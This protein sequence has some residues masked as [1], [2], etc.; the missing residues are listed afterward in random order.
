MAKAVLGVDV[1]AVTPGTAVADGR[2]MCSGLAHPFTIGIVKYTCTAHIEQVTCR[3]C[4]LAVAVHSHA[5]L[6]VALGTLIGNG[7]PEVE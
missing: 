3:D 5:V 2:A 6:G 4:L 1:H 7:P